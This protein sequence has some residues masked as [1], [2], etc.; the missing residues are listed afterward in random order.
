MFFAGPGDLIRIA[1]NG[2]RTTIMNDLVR[3][4]SLLV[5]ADNTIYVSN[6]GISVGTGEV[7]RILQ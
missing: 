5:D 1:P 6:R 7:L 4:T 3:P 2:T